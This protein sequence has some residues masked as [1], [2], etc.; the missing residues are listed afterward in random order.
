MLRPAQETRDRAGEACGPLDEGLTKEEAVQCAKRAKRMFRA[1]ETGML[2]AQEETAEV[3]DGV[4]L[5]LKADENNAKVRDA[6]LRLKMRGFG[7]SSQSINLTGKRVFLSEAISGD[8]LQKA[9]AAIMSGSMDRASVVHQA[10]ELVSV[11]WS[12]LLLCSEC[13]C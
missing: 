4:R 13:G 9:T 1:S 12:P 11:W 6:E 10:V 7:K 5:L 2:L 3:Q 8:A